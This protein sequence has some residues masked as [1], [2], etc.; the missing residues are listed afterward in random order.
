M[1]V[2]NDLDEYKNDEI[3]KVKKEKSTKLRKL[4]LRMR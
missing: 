3:N 2:D 1:F 4:N